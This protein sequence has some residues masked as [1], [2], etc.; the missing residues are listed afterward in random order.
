MESMLLKYV[1]KVLMWLLKAINT[2]YHI[3]ITYTKKLL[4]AAKFKWIIML[5]FWIY[6]AF[7]KISLKRKKA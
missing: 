3:Q 5:M 6:I 1:G 2:Q 7:H 4:K